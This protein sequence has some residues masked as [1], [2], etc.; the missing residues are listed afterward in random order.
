[1]LCENKSASNWRELTAV[2][3]GPNIPSTDE[4]LSRIISEQ[5]IGWEYLLFA[6]ALVLELARLET[7]YEDYK[8]RYA[9]RLGTAV[10]EPKFREY[11]NV[12][13]GELQDLVRNIDPLFRDEVIEAAFGAPGVAG[14]PARLLHLAKRLIGV[15]DDFLRWVERIRGTSFP[16][17]FKHLMEI[18]VEY[19]DQPIEEMRRFVQGYADFADR[20]PAV[21]ESGE[22]LKMEH[23]VTF[24]IPDAL[25]RAYREEFDRLR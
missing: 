19:A 8:L 14:D 22:P 2:I 13:L 12:Q 9:P 7:R 20:I 5:P 10:S 18:L 6:G 15:Y 24:S 25:S 17:Q 21:A 4:E 16:S 23:R 3:I 1:M 11:L